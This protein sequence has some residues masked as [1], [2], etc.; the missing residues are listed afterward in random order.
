L[1]QLFFDNSS[2]YEVIVLTGVPEEG[3][4]A[5]SWWAL[6]LAALGTNV[7]LI[8]ADAAFLLA[9]LGTNFALLLAG[10]AFLLAALGKYVALL[11]AGVVFFWLP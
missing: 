9:A 1:S 8:L 3:R 2:G 5:V 4:L 10:V 7:A 11:L 6:L